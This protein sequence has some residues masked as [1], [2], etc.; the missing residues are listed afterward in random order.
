MEGK[1]TDEVFDFFDTNSSGKITKTE[2][3]QGLAVIDQKANERQQ[4]KD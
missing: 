4:K 3:Y 1:T 2:F